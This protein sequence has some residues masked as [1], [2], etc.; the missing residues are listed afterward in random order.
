MMRVKV[1]VTSTGTPS[2][3][4]AAAFASLLAASM[5]KVPA[6]HLVKRAADA[7]SPQPNAQRNRG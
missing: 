3:A 6:L 7:E 4:G 2:L 1:K 5:A